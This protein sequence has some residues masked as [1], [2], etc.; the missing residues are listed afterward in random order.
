MERVASESE[1]HASESQSEKKSSS[2]GS[3]VCGIFWLF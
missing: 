1:A 3:I 2:H